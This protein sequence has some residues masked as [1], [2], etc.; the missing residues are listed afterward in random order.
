[1]CPLRSWPKKGIVSSSQ[2]RHPNRRLDPNGEVE[3]RRR[4]DLINDF[5]R[6]HISADLQAAQRD[7]NIGGYHGYSY[8]HDPSHVT[9]V[10]GIETVVE[11]V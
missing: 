10:R 7:T 8:N 4:I 2:A 11:R 3:I 6:A 9:A 1:M 5:F